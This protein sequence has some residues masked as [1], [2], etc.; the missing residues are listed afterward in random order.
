MDTTTN[1]SSYIAFPTHIVPSAKIPIE[2]LA[3][4]VKKIDA[5][6]AVQYKKLYD[7]RDKQG[8]KSKAWNT[9]YKKIQDLSN[10]KKAVHDDNPQWTWAVQYMNAMINYGRT[11]LTN[12]DQFLYE[13]ANATV[14]DGE[15]THI[16]ELYSGGYG[17]QLPAYLRQVNRA[18]AVLN[19]MC[20]LAD[21]T[22]LKYSV[23]V[24]NSDAVNEK[25]ER[26]AE[27]MADKLTT[28]ARNKAQVSQMLGAPVHPQDEAPQE[29]PEDFS[30]FNFSTYK[31]DEEVMIK[32]G[33]DF[34]MRSPD[35]AYKYKFS[36]MGFR[37]Y[38]T[39]S[40]MCFEVW[41]DIENPNVTSIDSRDLFY[42]LSPSSP[43][44][45]HGMGAG[46]YFAATPQELID[47]MPEMSADEV[48][49][50]RSLAVNYQGG[51]M[52]AELVQNNGCFEVK[53]RNKVQYLYLHCWKVNF[54]ATKRVRVRIIENK[55][56]V[57][58]PHI[59]YVS[60]SD[61][62]EGASYEYRYVEE[63]WEGYKYGA[64]GYYQLRPIPNQ[65]LVGDYLDKK[66]LNFIGIVDPNP[67]IVQLIQPFESLRIQV[68]YAIERLMAQVQGK[69]LCVDEANESDNADNA[70]NMKVYSV[71]RYNSAKEGDQQLVGVNG[72]KNL[73]KPEVLD[74]GLSSAITDLLRF[75][76]FLDVNVEAIT[77]IN[78]AAKGMLK[79]DTGLGQMEMAQAASSTQTQ[80]YFTTYY[81]VVQMTLEKI[82]EQMQRSWGGKD[83]VKTFLGQN[84]ME[85]L[86]LMKESQWHLHR[87]GVFVENGANDDIAK[88]KI[89][90]MA[91]TIAATAQD[92]DMVLG[93]I[94]IMN[95]N[96]AK[97]A[98]AIF[99]TGINALKKAQ[100]MA[101]AGQQ[102]MA[103]MQ[104][105]NAQMME[106]N[107]NLREQIK[108]KGSVEVA[109]VNKAAKLEDTEMKLE[110]D[111]NTQIVQ[112]GDELDKM[113]AEKELNPQEEVLET[114]E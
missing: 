91:E 1:P 72:A 104:Q 17:K 10:E 89:E 57:D 13:Y 88:A 99:E 106:E 113:V 53:L 62:T 81:T 84:G 101:Q 40:K 38:C 20:G 5:K 35:L 15:F 9:V 78:G 73:N 26:Y 109:N 45:Q 22:G 54:R 14:R 103:E 77:G 12:R 36:H 68:F 46:R 2:Q 3:G 69:I 87:Y 100:K 58:N 86:N 50:L 74:L 43:F 39:T 102:Q 70:Y 60:D 16:T 42:I 25:Q 11:S 61:N 4:E 71:Y 83:I 67:S 48:E 56:D 59:K 6:L 107:K 92:P 24:V 95:S 97:E 7:I 31:I 51:Q 29:I 33:L 96:S 79:S 44:I 32:R 34:L 64:D 65:H 82:C 98:E 18:P 85:L 8:E 19:R 41:D 114:A 108:V 76:A 93:L 21:E 94:K 55:F 27:E 52:G 28:L 66:T 111:T 49:R 63:I 30:T 23:S 37:N 105:K 112:K 110:H 80:P 75:V 47:M 90:R